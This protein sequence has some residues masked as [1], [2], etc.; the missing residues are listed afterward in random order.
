MF[1]MARTVP[2]MFTGS[3]GSC[4]TTRTAL[5]GRSDIGNHEREI[6]ARLAAVAAEIDPAVPHATEDELP[7]PTLATRLGLV[8]GDD[9]IDR[10]APER[11]LRQRR[12]EH[13]PGG[14][15]PPAH[16]DW[17]WRAFPAGAPHP[18]AAPGFRDEGPRRN[19]A[20]R[21]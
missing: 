6:A 12:T 1:F 15:A 19:D 18:H 8:H 2:A 21:R 16:L 17:H 13:V 5:S 9:E 10:L 3:C 11:R 20:A 14:V 4:S 7:A